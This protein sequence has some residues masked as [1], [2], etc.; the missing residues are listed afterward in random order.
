MLSQVTRYLYKASLRPSL[1]FCSS[2][3]EQT[4]SS[5]D[6]TQEQKTPVWMKPYD[7]AKYEVPSN[8]I[9]LHT[10]YA[11]LDVEPMPKARIMKIGYIVL[12]KL[13]QIPEGTLCRIF[14]EEKT[15][16]IMEK[17]DEID[18]IEELEIVLGIYCKSFEK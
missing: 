5:L 6:Q 15:K 11:L 7:A 1:R 4:Q 13:Q 18:D 10:G 16:W 3:T 9:K 12:D 17:T 14:H 2:L 8:K